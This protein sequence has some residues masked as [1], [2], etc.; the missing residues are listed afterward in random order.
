[1]GACPLLAESKIVYPD[2]W[3]KLPIPDVA[4]DA[5]QPVVD[6]VE[7]ILAAKR[8]DA[9]A[10]VTGLEREI[11]RIVYNLYGLNEREATLIEK[12]IGR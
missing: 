6:L 11:D 10:D 5:Q 4:L 7:D 1:M 12:T 2:D 9:S 3:K 8:A